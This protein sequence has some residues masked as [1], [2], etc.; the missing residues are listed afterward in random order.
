LANLHEN[1][2]IDSAGKL[3]RSTAE[4][5]SGDLNLANNNFNSNCELRIS[6]LQRYRPG[7]NLVWF[8]L[9]TSSLGCNHDRYNQQEVLSERVVLP[10][11][12]DRR[13][14]L[15]APKK[16]NPEPIVQV[17]AI[18]NG[19][20]APSQTLTLAEAI[21]TAFRQ[22]PRLRVYLEGVEQARRGEDV[23]FAPYLPTAVAGVSAGGFDLNVNGS[24][25]NF[26]FLPGLGALPFGLNI[27]TGYEL[28]EL[29]LQW[30]ICDFGRRSGK[31]RQAGLTADIAQLQCDRAYQTVANEVAVAY[32]QVL[33]AR[34]LRTTALDAVRRAE[35]DLK[36]AKQLAEGGV[37][38]K[39]KALRV[40]VLLAENRRALDATEGAE[41]VSIAALNF[42]IGLNVNAATMVQ[43]NSDIPPFA[44][45]LADCLQTAVELRREFQVAR[46][47]IDV[48]DEGRKVAKASFAPR[49]LAE[50]ALF[51]FQQAAPTGR[52]DLAV[53]SIRLEW[54]LFEGGKRVAELRV[55]DAKIRSAMAEADSIADSIAFQVTEA[56]HNL[57]TAQKAIALS[58]PAVGQAK[59]NR[60]NVR[61][62][63]KAGDATSADITDAEATLT[64]AEQAY[65]NANHDFFIASARLEYAMGVT[66]T[67][68]SLVGGRC[69]PARVTVQEAPASA[70]PNVTPAIGFVETEPDS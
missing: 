48:A 36:V 49:I 41:V 66:P 3:V 20:V 34:A 50:G 27:N 37:V 8:V 28:A 51:D 57:I 68:G 38:E 63:A 14:E 11:K 24:A 67:P 32:Y 46:R 35:D 21:E 40:E 59:T 15:P 29:K 58:R 22:Q 62:R 70:Q 39:E 53:G 55:A 13:A 12:D 69:S 52:A 25:N 1:W 33:R 10:P 19:H 26:G 45:T 65:L 47:T 43:E 64:R 9:L 61:A 31:Y 54:G 30:L 2:A 44:R 23:A 16:A 56:Y 18:D 4:R 60:D 5:L 7:L 42:A 17:Q 6:N